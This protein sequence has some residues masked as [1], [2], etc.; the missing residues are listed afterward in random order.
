MSW[1][2]AISNFLHGADP[3]SRSDSPSS[4]TERVSSLTGGVDGQ[5]RPVTENRNGGR[6]VPSIAATVAPIAAASVTDASVSD[7][8]SSARK[9]KSDVDTS[10]IARERVRGRGRGRGA[11]RVTS[12]RRTE[13]RAHIAPHKTT[14][15]WGSATP[16]PTDPQHLCIQGTTM[17]SR[18]HE[19]STSM[20]TG[21]GQA[22]QEQGAVGPSA[23]GGASNGK[24]HMA[25]SDHPGA[26]VTDQGMRYM[27]TSFGPVPPSQPVG[28]NASTVVACI[29]TSA[30]PRSKQTHLHTEVHHL[31]PG[32]EHLQNAQGPST[33]PAATAAL[34]P[35]SSENAIQAAAT[36]SQSSWSSSAAPAP[37]AGAAH[38]Q[39]QAQL[40]QPSHEVPSTVPMPGKR[41]IGSKVAERRI[42]PARLRRVSNLLGGPSSLTEDE[43]R[44]EHFKDHQQRLAYEDHLLPGSTSLIITNDPSI[45][46]KAEVHRDYYFRDAMSRFTDPEVARACRAAAIIETPDFKPWDEVSM[47]GRTR[48]Q[49]AEEDTSD[50]AY[51]RRHRKPDNAEKRVRK[52]EIDRVRIERDRLQLRLDQ[53]RAIEAEKLL[54]ILASRSTPAPA[55]T[56]V[57]PAA[58]TSDHSS[59]SAR[60]G[61]SS[62]SAQLEELRKDLI[63]EAKQML[64]R[65]DSLLA[66]PPPFPDRPKA[67]E[68]RK[69]SGVFGNFTVAA[70][71]AGAQDPLSDVGPPAGS[72]QTGRKSTGRGGRASTVTTSRGGRVVGRKSLPATMPS[73]HSGKPSENAKKGKSAVG[74]AVAGGMRPEAT[75]AEKVRRAMTISAGRRS[76]N[77]GRNGSSTNVS[78]ERVHI[79]GREAVG[80]LLNNQGRVEQVF[81]EDGKPNIHARTS[82]GR[83][84]PKPRNPDGTIKRD[85]PAA[86]TPAPSKPKPAPKPKARSSRVNPRRA[87]A[88]TSPGTSTPA[89]VSA[90]GNAAAHPAS[91]L[92]AGG[93]SATQHGTT[94]ST[95]GLKR[96]RAVSASTS[97]SARTAAKVAK[98]ERDVRQSSAETTASGSIVTR[99]RFNIIGRT[100]GGRFAS[101]KEL[102]V[103]G[104]GMQR[105]PRRTSNVRALEESPGANK[106]GPSLAEIAASTKAPNKRVRLTFNNAGSESGSPAPS[107]RSSTQQPAKKMKTPGLVPAYKP[108]ALSEEEAQKMLEAALAGDDDDDLA[109][110]FGSGATGSS[111]ATMADASAAPEPQVAPLSG[112]ATEVAAAASDAK[113]ELSDCATIQSEG[114]AYAQ[115]TEQDASS[116]D[117][118]P[119]LGTSPENGVCA[120]AL[121]ISADP[122]QDGEAGLVVASSTST[123]AASSVPT[124]SA[125][126]AATAAAFVLDR[127]QPLRRGSTRMRSITAFGEKLP[128]PLT[129]EADFAILLEPVMQDNEWSQLGVQTER[130]PYAPSQPEDGQ[131]PEADLRTQQDDGK[132][133]APLAQAPLEQK[134]EMATV[135]AKDFTPDAGPHLA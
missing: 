79:A 4:R 40:Q 71:G 43:F 85:A 123:D 16:G 83:F 131:A 127:N 87:A 53:L 30:A 61:G 70:T 110:L 41:T 122:P 73:H 89:L 49:A 69:V 76:H 119:A 104:E 8:Q 103:P 35:P 113:A 98:E 107:D 57:A 72:R 29:S 59:T 1:T 17:D 28:N 63:Q 22:A 25:G 12:A 81:L 130:L 91:A 133:G 65:L 62:E 67:S 27:D 23:H 99:E 121:R 64:Q 39:T 7:T 96:K 92:T 106:V 112:S 77:S 128:E 68:K 48:I 21:P 124:S 47:G 36:L 14:K 116:I 46:L 118:K 19:L 109:I 66:L 54:P 84:A 90:A 78:K 42:L 97:V 86:G 55:A 126:A 125:P 115:P 51:E 52:S 94:T 10:G 20:L 80:S 6:T 111:S 108:A 93:T 117:T 132:G 15:S 26:R 60:T 102:K 9:E 74:T 82:G 45:I 129:K 88:I 2:A 38:S 50:E 75:R 134:L 101:K 5:Q 135:S 34:I 100:S 58:S 24:P 56:A 3:S 11:P 33:V 114:S 95:A 32:A 13:A 31:Q 105:S 44:P 18:I 120:S 37:T